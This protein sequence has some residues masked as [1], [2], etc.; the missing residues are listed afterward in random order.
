MLAAHC[1]L[2]SWIRHTKTVSEYWAVPA[3]NLSGNLEVAIGVARIAGASQTGNI[4]FLQGKTLLS[5]W[6][7]IVGVWV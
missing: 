6:K 3:C 1:Q 4:N 2:E 7:I 5:L